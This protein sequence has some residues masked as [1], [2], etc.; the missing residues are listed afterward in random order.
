MSLPV[1]S[2]PVLPRGSSFIALLSQFRQFTSVFV[3]AER[4][5]SQARVRTARLPSGQTTVQQANVLGSNVFRGKR[6]RLDLPLSG[7]DFLDPYVFVDCTE[8]II[9]VEVISDAPFV[10]QVR[11]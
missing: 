3:Y 8:G 1:H 9:R 7:G 11:G 10:T 4:A 2:L 6:V 5:G